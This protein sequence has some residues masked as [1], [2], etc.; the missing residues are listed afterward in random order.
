TE[1]GWPGIPGAGWSAG[2]VTFVR[3][4]ADRKNV[5]LRLTSSTDG[6]TVGTHQAQVCQQRKF[7]EGT[8]AT[9]IRFA[10]RP[11]AGPGGDQVVEAFY[12]ISPLAAPL[13]PDFS[14]LDWEYLPNGGWGRTGPTLWTT[15]WE[16][17]RLDPWL[18][19]NVTL[20]T[21][22]A[23]AGWHTL[24]VQVRNGSVTYYLDG[25]RRVVHG[26]RY[27]PEAPM[28]LN[29]TAWFIDGGLLAA[30]PVRSYVQDVDWAL[31][32]A[33]AVLRPQQVV[34]QVAAFRKAGVRFRDTVP[35]P[36][37]PLASPCNL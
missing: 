14:E 25:A 29:Y 32:A 4:P 13:D 21:S 3:D 35:S 30:G 10:D 16:T 33:G 22:G 7:R 23:L 1:Q 12:G 26:G 5:L 2:N 27:Y 18:A 19:D 11:A 15:T 37:P 20:P 34:A 24:V 17:A 28:S 9:R 8:W 6:T 31:Q 36:Q